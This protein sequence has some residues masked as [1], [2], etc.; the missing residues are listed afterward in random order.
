MVVTLY[1]EDGASLAWA[2]WGF[3]STVVDGGQHYLLEF[4]FIFDLITKLTSS[5]HLQKH[6]LLT[7]DLPVLFAIKVCV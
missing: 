4:V 6:S 1:Q 7:V 2:A 3:I 5:L